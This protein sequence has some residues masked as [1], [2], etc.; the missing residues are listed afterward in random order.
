MVWIWPRLCEF[1]SHKRTTW[2][3]TKSEPFR[4]VVFSTESGSQGFISNFFLVIFLSKM[5]GSYGSGSSAKPTGVSGPIFGKQGFLLEFSRILECFDSTYEIASPENSKNRRLG[6]FHLLWGGCGQNSESKLK[7]VIDFVHKKLAPQVSTQNIQISTQE[8][9]SKFEKVLQVRF[10]DPFWLREGSRP[11][12]SKIERCTGL[13]K[14]ISNRMEQ[15]LSFDSALV[16]RH[17]EPK[18]WGVQKRSKIH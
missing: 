4:L 13:E 11:P 1:N 16:R 17:F 10:G 12:K 8:G 3:Y 7:Y 14:T 15:F 18:F 6:C 9:P 5:V 2:T